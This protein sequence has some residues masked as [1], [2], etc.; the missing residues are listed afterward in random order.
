MNIYTYGKYMSKEMTNKV[1]QIKISK[2]LNDYCLY[3]DIGAEYL[4]CIPTRV[5]G[6]FSYCFYYKLTD[7]QIKKLKFK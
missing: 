6:N 1:S 3:T 2:H 7:S 5:Y 4:S